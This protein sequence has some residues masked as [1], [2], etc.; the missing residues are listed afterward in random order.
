MDKQTFDKEILSQ[1]QY[2][3]VLGLFNQVA[4]ERTAILKGAQ[5]LKVARR[6]DVIYLYGFSSIVRHGLSTQSHDQLA[7][8]SPELTTQCSRW[9]DRSQILIS[10]LQ[11]ARNAAAVTGVLGSALVYLPRR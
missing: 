1:V 7:V 5:E 2:N 3:H 11:N 6:V 9:F 4:D 10:Q 8:L